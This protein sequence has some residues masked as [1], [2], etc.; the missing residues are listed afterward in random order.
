M[1]TEA[2]EAATS[3]L[4]VPIGAA[5]AA[6]GIASI[7]AMDKND[8]NFFTEISLSKSIP[9]LKYSQPASTIA[10]FAPFEADVTMVGKSCGGCSANRMPATYM[11]TAVDFKY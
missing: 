3:M 5:L 2:P 9:R 1:V 11:A 4:A 10:A 8:K 6:T 7:A